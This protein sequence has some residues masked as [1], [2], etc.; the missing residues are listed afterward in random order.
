MNDSMTIYALSSGLGRAGIAVVRVSG[1]AACDVVVK[2]ARTLPA[3]RMAVV[4]RLHDPSTEETIDEAV[5]LWLPGPGTV[6]GE[7]MAEFHLHGSPAIVTMFLT[8][9]GHQTS[10]R[11]A[12]A[13][14]FTRR[15]FENGRMDLVEVEGLADL[16]AADSQGQ[17][18][19]AMRQFLGEASS[20]YESWRNEL[21][22][23][24]AMVEAAIDFVDED[25]V[26]ASARGLVVP[27][28]AALVEQLQAALAQSQRASA[29]R[30]GL[31]VVIAGPPNA[32]KSSL[33]N[34]LAARQVAIV[35]AIAGTTR[36]VIEA[37]V[38]L[39]G[40]PVV[41]T[42]TAGIRGTTSDEIEAVGI[43]RAHQEVR[44]ADFL[45]WVMSPDSDMGTSPPR[46]PD[47]ELF[48]KADLD[49]GISIHMRNESGMAISLKSGLGLDAMLSRL[50][51]QLST[52]NS[53]GENAIVVRER[54]RRAIED[55]IRVLNHAIDSRD[56]PLEIV[57]ESLRRAAR[58][59]ASITGRVDVEDLLGRI[60]SE[61]CI[62]K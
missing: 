44:D 40:L 57:A 55:S 7:D 50:T 15:A 22:G 56:A 14:E 24:A 60:F 43:E 28:I 10:L 38:T 4:R 13:G 59:M 17:R 11:M 53:V 58:T 37:P 51:E 23:A 30:S 32:G 54:H 48:N 19:L 12:E 8:L 29:I 42:D 62:G 31:K 20:I 16:L 52:A 27:R 61:F 5:V 45:I 6:T 21:I 33:L 34:F 36:D 3:P 25:D 18:R 2:F 47:L 41:L 26:V 39:G 49:A 1:K 9:L 46:R 35:S